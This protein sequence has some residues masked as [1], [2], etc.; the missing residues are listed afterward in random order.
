M[1]NALVRSNDNFPILSGDITEDTNT[2]IGELNV[3]DI[4]VERGMARLYLVWRTREFLSATISE[5]ECTNCGFAGQD[6]TDEHCQH[7][8]GIISES[9]VPVYPTLESYISYVSDETGKSRQTLFDRLRT[10]RVLSD[11]RGVSPISV[12]MLNLLSSGAAKK[13]ASANEKD[14]LITLVNDSWQDTVGAA[15]EFD[16]KSQALQFVKYDVLHEPKIS[17]EMVDSDT[18]I[19]YYER[20]DPEQCT[21]DSY[22][23]KLVGQWT[24]SMVEW[25]CRKLGASIK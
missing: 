13:L 24:E 18:F 15:L 2:I 21:V 3:G 8:G 12:F 25:F 9:E 11:E 1:T 7:C 20:D 4:V 5:Y 23:V 22:E 6:I 19:V 10:Y 16:S 14:S 17:S